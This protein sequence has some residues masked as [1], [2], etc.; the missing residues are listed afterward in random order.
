MIIEKGQSETQNPSVLI[1]ETHKLKDI[2]ILTVNEFDVDGSLIFE[3][4]SNKGD[5][6]FGKFSYKPWSEKKPLY[7]ELPNGDIAS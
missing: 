5:K 2:S 7:F 6:F 1:N 4:R 3:I